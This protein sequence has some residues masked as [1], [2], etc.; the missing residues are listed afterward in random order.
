VS[1][2]FAARLWALA[3]VAHSECGEPHADPRAD[4]MREL[5]AKKA[6]KALAKYGLE[7]ADLKTDL[8]CLEQAERIGK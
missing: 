2:K 7:K 4:K 6:Q 5:A 1:I 8:E 3:I